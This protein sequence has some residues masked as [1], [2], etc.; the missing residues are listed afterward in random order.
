MELHQ[1]QHA[2][3]RHP[4]MEI[5]VVRSSLSHIYQIECITDDGQQRCLSR[6]GK[7]RLFRSID[8]AVDELQGVGL[9]RAWIVRHPDEEEG[10][11]T[12]R[13]LIHLDD[14]APLR[15]AI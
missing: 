15:M 10:G 3:A 1:L 7:P 13:R 11:A 8:E 5:R 14:N 9:R 4:D 12:S 6:R 2:A